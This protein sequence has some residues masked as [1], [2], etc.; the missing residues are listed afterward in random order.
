MLKIDTENAILLNSIK[1]Y[2][3]VEHLDKYLDNK[4]EKE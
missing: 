4:I 2:L 3:K 1:T